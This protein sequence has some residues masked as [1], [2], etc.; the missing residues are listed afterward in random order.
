M[1]S[2]ISIYLTHPTRTKSFQTHAGRQGLRCREANQSIRDTQ[3]CTT[4]VAETRGEYLRGYRASSPRNRWLRRHALRLPTVDDTS[5][6]D[7]PTDKERT[8]GI[9]HNRTASSFSANPAP[10]SLFRP[11]VLP[12]RT[13]T[14]R[15]DGSLHQYSR[16]PTLE[17]STRLSRT[18][19]SSPNGAN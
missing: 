11:F 2:K 8:P 18:G 4:D 12:N 16:V 15:W 10:E 5:N 13:A 9:A 7:V 6:A 19:F 14:V 17:P 1:F 3:V